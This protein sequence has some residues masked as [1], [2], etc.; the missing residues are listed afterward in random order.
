MPV[1]PARMP[2]WRDGRPLKRWRYIGAYGAELMLCAGDVRIGP[3]RQRFWAAATPD[4]RIAEH[5]AVFGSSGL[6]LAG[7]RVVIDAARLRARLA[8]GERPAVETLSP[9]GRS[10]IWTRKQGGVPVSGLVE[11][12][13]RPYQLDC[14]GV[15]DDSAGYHARHT[16]WAW[17]A[18][19]G[20]S[21]DGRRVAWNLVAGVHDDPRASERTVWVD[22][23]PQEVEAVEFARDLSAIRSG[24]GELRFAKWAVRENRTNAVLLRSWYRQPFGEFV[25]TL[26]G[27]VPLAR[28]YGVMEAHDVYW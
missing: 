6:V 17:S 16:A 14:E 3:L 12:D 23:S 15:V 22:G 1:P 20:R 25:G 10:Y 28:G 8:V 24:S 9:H 19:V 26:P 2:L 4:G 11:L 21:G 5:T 13:G 7:D 18:G 27:G